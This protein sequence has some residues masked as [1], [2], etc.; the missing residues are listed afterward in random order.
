[1]RAICLAFLLTAGFVVF[2]PA[3]SRADD[4]IILDLP[5]INPQSK[6]QTTPSDSTK[7][8]AYLLSDQ[9]NLT[10]EFIQNTFRGAAPGSM[11][12]VRVRREARSFSLSSATPVSVC[13]MPP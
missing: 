11:I 13:E 6:A 2:A 3:I 8:V 4:T 1:M 7:Q 9:L 5:A 10:L 12:H